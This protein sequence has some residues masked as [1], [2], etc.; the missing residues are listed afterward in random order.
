MKTINWSSI[1]RTL[2]LLVT[3]LALSFASFAQEKPFER[4]VVFGTSLSDPG[5]GFVLLSDP[6]AFGFDENCELGTPANV[7]PYDSLDE[8]V[9]PDGTYARGG[10]HV[11]NGATWVEQLARGQGLSGNVR[12][13]LR[14]PGLKAS[15]YAVGGA[16]AASDYPC[17][18]NL[19]NQL[20]EYFA[21]F[22]ETSANALVVIEM[23]GNDV[24]DALVDPDPLTVITEAI[25]Q[26]NN[27]IQELHLK[28]ARHFLL[29]NVPAI[30]QTPAIQTLNY[31]Y[32]ALDIANSANLLARGFNGALAELQDGLNSGLPG[33]DIRTLDLYSLLNKIIA[34]PGDYDITTIDKACVTPNVPPF[35]CKKPDTYLFWDGIHPTK[36][37]HGF[38]AD[39]AAEVLEID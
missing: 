9:I 27:T 24:R 35:A 20:E 19:A 17:R 6:Y 18:F 32:P 29:V 5:N 28:G 12:P 13:A 11:T 8:L 15:N 38:M 25:T 21:D 33:V 37:V 2:T 14:N 34:T 22:P 4:I 26:I 31:L 36:A 30:G 16:R 10:H 23:G 39:E 1:T 3:C 7:P